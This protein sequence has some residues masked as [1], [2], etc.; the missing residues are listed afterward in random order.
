[1]TD[2]Y[3]KVVKPSSRRRFLGDLARTAGGVALLGLGVGVYSRQAASLPATAIRP[4]GA[5]SEEQFLREI[6][7]CFSCGLC[8]GCRLCWMYCGGNGFTRLESPGPGRYFAFS[9][10]ECTGCGKCIELCPTGFLGEAP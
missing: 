10:E 9:T 3:D 2:A 8:N 7:R 5:L 1:M 4:P 6:S